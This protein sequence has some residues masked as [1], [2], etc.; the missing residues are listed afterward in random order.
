VY[1]K[2]KFR[3]L[4]VCKAQVKNTKEHRKILFSA[5]Q[6]L[7]DYLTDYQS[8]FKNKTKKFFDKAQQYTQGRLV[9]QQRNIEQISDTLAVADYFQLQHFITESF[10]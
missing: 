9:S 2:T 3:K 4:R 1:R 8:V 10:G 6:R 7:V 5:Y